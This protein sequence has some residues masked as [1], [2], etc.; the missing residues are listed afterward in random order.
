[1]T[2]TPERLGGGINHMVPLLLARWLASDL[3]AAT[4]VFKHVASLWNGT[5]FLDGAA[6]QSQRFSTRDLTYFLWAARA[7][8]GVKG[9]ETQ[10]SMLAAVEARLWALQA[11]EG[12]T[13]VA[14][15]YRGEGEALCPPRDGWGAGEQLVSIEANAMALSL[16]DPRM[17]TVWFPR[18]LG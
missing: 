13:A 8:A 5:G 4:S 1:V 6:L 17:T 16:A 2:F 11:C 3:P 7:T 10:P 14:V 15:S 18:K 9:F 12:G